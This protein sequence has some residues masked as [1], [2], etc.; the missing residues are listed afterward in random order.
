M[1]FSPTPMLWGTQEKAILQ[2]VRPHPAA[3]GTDA[4]VVLGR[5]AAGLQNLQPDPPATHALQSRKILE[6]DGEV[7]TSLGIL[8]RK[9]TTDEDWG[10]IGRNHQD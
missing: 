2:P 9:S 1:L 10:F 8:G 5:I 6:R 4:V 3:E 7:P